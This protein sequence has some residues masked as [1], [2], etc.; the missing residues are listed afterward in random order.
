MDTDFSGFSQESIFGGTEDGISV[1]I[2]QSYVTPRLMLFGSVREL[3]QSGSKG[4]NE[5]SGIP[6]AS[7]RQEG[8]EIRDALWISQC[9]V[10]L[11]FSVPRTDESSECFGDRR[12]FAAMIGR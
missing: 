2:K 1:G 4:N 8:R 7:G 6:G 10:R 11:W 5:S 9:L 12:F 3:T